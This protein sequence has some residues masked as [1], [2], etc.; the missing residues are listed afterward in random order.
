MMRGKK[1]KEQVKLVDSQK[2]YMPNE[3]IS[4]VKKMKYAGFDESV[5]VH[6]NLGIDPRHADQQLRG[7]L[8][9]PHGTG[10]KIKILVI[11]KDA[12]IKEAEDAGA[13]YAGS[14]EM[15]EKIQGGW[16]GFDLII[17]APDMMSKVGKLGRLLGSKGLMPSPKSGTVTQDIGKA[18]SEFKGGK[19]EYRNDKTG[20]VH[21]V[22]GKLSFQEEQLLDNFNTVYDTLMKI[23]PTKAKGLYM[24]SISVNS[25]MGPGV[26][27]EQMKNKWKDFD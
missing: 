20:I 16:F 12:K 27:V 19:L 22:I 25:S 15:I 18:V 21:L 1:Y 24:K 23:K 10:K 4:L 8:L 6:F 14:D 9:L 26:F 5:E 11:A 7:T 13:D 2:K 17:A 3:A